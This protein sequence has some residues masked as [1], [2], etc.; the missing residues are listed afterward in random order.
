MRPAVA[1]APKKPYQTPKLFIYG[2]LIEMTQ[3]RSNRGGTDGA[4]KGARRKT[5]A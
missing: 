4:T 5:G 1:T 2:N 3:A